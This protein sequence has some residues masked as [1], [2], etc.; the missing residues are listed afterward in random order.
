MSFARSSTAV[1]DTKR[2]LD[3]VAPRLPR[4]FRRLF[5]CRFGFHKKFCAVDPLSRQHHAYQAP[6]NRPRRTASAEDG[7]HREQERAP[8]SWR[9]RSVLGRGRTQAASRPCRPGKAT[10]HQR[11][12]RGTPPRTPGVLPRCWVRPGSTSDPSPLRARTRRRSNP[13]S[14]GTAQTSTSILRRGRR[15]ANL[16][17]E[18]R[19]WPA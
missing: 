9:R 19:R 18:T 1:I 17:I 13:R 5:F 2:C 11:G 10:N 16:I 7:R 12:R 14:R 8:Q 6:S 15:R 4:G 3:G